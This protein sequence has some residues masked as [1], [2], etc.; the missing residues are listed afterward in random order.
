MALHR[1]YPQSAVPSIWKL[2]SDIF[3]SDIAFSHRL[4]FDEVYYNQDHPD[5]LAQWII[6]FKARFVL[7]TDR[8]W[9]LIADIVKKNPK[10]IDSG[11]KKEQADPWLIA[12]LIEEQE[13]RNVPCILVTQESKISSDKL[14]AACKSFGLRSMNMI[15]FFEE[16]SWKV[17]VTHQKK[18]ESDDEPL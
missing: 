15:E 8:Q 11:C 18:L 5:A 14:P 3:I 9:E 12:L 13:K 2:L 17:N 6:P 10:L 7:K 1:Y 16:N 4:V